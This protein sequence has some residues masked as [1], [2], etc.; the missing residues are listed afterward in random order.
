MLLLKTYLNHREIGTPTPALRDWHAADEL[1]REIMKR[2]VEEQGLRV[3]EEPTGL[4]YDDI[5]H[6]VILQSVDEAFR[7]ELR[8]VELQGD[9]ASAIV[10]DLSTLMGNIRHARS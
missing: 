4:H 9:V 10:H 8:I 7:L 2:L 1:R 5:P 6:S 3:R